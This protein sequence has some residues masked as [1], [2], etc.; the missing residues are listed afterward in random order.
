MNV[1]RYIEGSLRGALPNPAC[2]SIVYDCLYNFSAC[3][4][5][6][7]VLN[8]DKKKLEVS[9]REWG[10]RITFGQLSLESEKVKS[11]DFKHLKCCYSLKS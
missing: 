4:V 10:L 11:I 7:Y 8:I 6:E 5:Y 1:L 2:L 9:R 3:Y